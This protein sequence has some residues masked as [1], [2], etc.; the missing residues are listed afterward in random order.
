[1]LEADGIRLIISTPSLVPENVVT[2]DYDPDALKSTV[3]ISG[4]VN[5][6]VPDQ[7]VPPAVAYA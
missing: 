3:V 7:S 6:V 5:T 1:M 4:L 2:A